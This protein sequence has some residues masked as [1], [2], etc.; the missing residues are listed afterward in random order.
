MPPRARRETS[1]LTAT[2]RSETPRRAKVR[3]RTHTVVIDDAVERGGTDK[4]PNPPET[5]LASMAGCLNIQMNRL[6]KERGIALRNIHLS[7]DADFD[8][9]GVTWGEDVARPFPLV[10][11]S[12][13]GNSDASKNKLTALRRDMLRHCPVSRVLLEGGTRFRQSWDIS[14]L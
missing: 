8:R 4:G 13:T 10:R 12:V 9:R 14:A 5:F 3:I 11:I 2:A 6:A 1:R 7:I